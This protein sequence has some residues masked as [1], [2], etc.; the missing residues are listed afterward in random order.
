MSIMTM[1]IFHVVRFSHLLISSSIV[2]FIF[3]FV[4]VVL[5]LVFMLKQ[6]LILK[7]VRIIYAFVA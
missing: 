6:I 7:F 3:K 5:I 4:Y 2:K 1:M